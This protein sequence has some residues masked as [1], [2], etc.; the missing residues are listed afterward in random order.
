MLERLEPW[1]GRRA[2]HLTPRGNNGDELIVRG[3]REAFRRSGIELVSDPRRAEVV[4]LKGG[5]WLTVRYP[6]AIDFVRRTLLTIPRVPLIGLPGSV[7]VEPETVA[8]LVQ[9]REA[10]CMFARDVHSLAILDSARAL[11]PTLDAAIDHDTAFILEDSEWVA[12]LRRRCRERH[13]LIVERRDREQIVAG[14]VA[15]VHG[16]TSGA[17]P[18]KAS[19]LRRALPE[20]IKQRLR[21]RRALSTRHSTPPATPTA[22]QAL[23]LFA[24]AGAPT[25]ERAIWADLSDDV[26]FSFDTFVRLIVDA[27]MV[28]STR[29]HV[30]ILAALL[31]KPVFLQDGPYHKFRGAFETSLSR[32]PNARLAGIP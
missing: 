32:F 21:E 6:E 15:G 13:L 1:R 14:G 24:E 7:E 26:V 19:L 25:G 30:A 29:L 16:V 18:P 22:T 3:E 4:L 8:D 2:F 31:G 27:S 5:G 12:S 9:G 17:A 20:P 11:A 23:R 10:C 28:Y